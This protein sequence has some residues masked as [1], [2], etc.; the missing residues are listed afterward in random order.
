MR[1]VLCCEVEFIDEFGSGVVGFLY[2]K[3]IC[4]EE[5]KEKNKIFDWVGF[6]VYMYFIFEEDFIIL[7][8]LVWVC[9]VLF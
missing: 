5:E 4:N 9:V 7:C 3:G 6:V 2:V 8:G 1:W